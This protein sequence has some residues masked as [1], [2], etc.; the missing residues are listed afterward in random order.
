MEEYLQWWWG[1]L[2]FLWEAALRVAQSCSGALRCCVLLQSCV[3][4]VPEWILL[5]EPERS[6]QCV[7][8]VEPPTARS[9]QR[10]WVA[11]VL[12]WVFGLTAVSQPPDFLSLS[13]KRESWTVFYCLW[14]QLLGM[15]KLPS[16]HHLLSVQW[17]AGHSFCKRKLCRVWSQF[18]KAFKHV[19]QSYWY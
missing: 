18:S 11:V 4:V 7:G 8:T 14:T 5:A 10:C 16:P 1:P 2:L 13:V 15:E 12:S 3:P 6:H 9:Q 19:L 17:A